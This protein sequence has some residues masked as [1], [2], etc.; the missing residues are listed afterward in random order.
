MKFLLFKSPWEKAENIKFN[1]IERI[2]FALKLSSNPDYD[3]NKI[4]DAIYWIVEFDEDGI[5]IREIGLDEND[6]VILKIPY[7]KNY[8]YWIDNNMK[9]QDFISHFDAKKIDEKYFNEK[10][11]EYLI[12]FFYRKIFL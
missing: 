8:G 12:V 2:I 3:R 10:W 11:Q 9:Y 1:F 5:P 7:K 6:N 4:N